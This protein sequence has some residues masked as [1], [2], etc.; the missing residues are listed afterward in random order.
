MYSLVLRTIGLLICLTALSGI[1]QLQAT[2]VSVELLMLV[3]VSSSIDS[4][5]YGIQK[6][7]YINAFLDPVIQA[8]IAS[9]TNGIAVSY[10]EFSGSTQRS[11]LVGWTHLTDAASAISFSSAIAGTSRAFSGLTAPGSAINW[12]VNLINNN[13]YEGAHLV[14]DVSGDGQ[15]NSGANTLN[16]AAAAFAADIQVNGLPI[17][18][19]T[20]AQWYQTNIVTPGH[21]FLQVANS[22]ADFNPAL[23]QKLQSEISGAPEPASLVLLGSGILALG[24]LRRKRT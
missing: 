15:Q 19:A 6:N 21:G 13:G 18:G 22:F 5:E 23:Q 7:G 20:L 4:T 14:I 9:S 1:S 11:Q 24:L 17:G 2:P 16:A 3:D 8:L 12:A 10:A